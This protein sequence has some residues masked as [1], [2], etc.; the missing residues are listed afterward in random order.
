MNHTRKKFFEK[1]WRDHPEGSVLT[2]GWGNKASQEDRF[3]RLL[4]VGD[5]KDKSVLDVGCGMG[6][7]YRYMCWNGHE[8]SRYVG[9]DMMEDTI[10]KAKAFHSKEKDCVKSEVEFICTDLASY[11]AGTFDYVVAS[12]IFSVKTDDW[13][14]HMV[15]TVQKMLN[16]STTGVAINFLSASHRNKVDGSMYVFPSTVLSALMRDVSPWVVLMHDYRT[17]D[18]TVLLYKE[19]RSS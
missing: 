14:P 3:F 4:D 2:V 8:P 6:D 16:I 1:L 5:M 17:N 11:D 12:G 19:K 13:W 9:I 7:F 10:E 15:S 18:F